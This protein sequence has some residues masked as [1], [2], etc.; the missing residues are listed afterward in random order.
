MVAFKR[1]VEGRRWWK[2][3]RGGVGLGGGGGGGGL[4]LV[5]EVGSMQGCTSTLQGR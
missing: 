3:S 5:R 2:R 4:K 1:L